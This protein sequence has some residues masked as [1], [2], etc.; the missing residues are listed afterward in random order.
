MLFFKKII[1]DSFDYNF[2]YSSKFWVNLKDFLSTNK[3]HKF[4]TLKIISKF[5]LV[6]TKYIYI[7]STLNK[8]VD[9]RNFGN[10]LL[11]IGNLSVCLSSSRILKRLDHL[12]LFKEMLKKLH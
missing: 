5:V 6:L 9:I 2:I 10:H 11:K 8:N 12:Y 3:K 7:N 1:K 4:L